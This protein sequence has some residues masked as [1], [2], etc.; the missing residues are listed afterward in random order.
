MIITAFEAL[1][2]ALAL[3]PSSSFT[4]F[5][6]SVALAWGGE[7]E[8]AIEWAE[9]ALRVSPVDRLNYLAYHG[10]A[11]GHFLRG[12]YEEATNAARRGVQS[13]PGFSV[14]RSLLAAPL[15]KL[16]RMEEASAVAK[17]VLE[18]E[19]SFSADGFC[20]ALAVPAALAKPLVEAWREAGLPP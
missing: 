10:L 17:C 11:V 6:G 14:S 8:R 18:L 15:A 4:L 9:R 2:Q 1:E 12:R 20:S 5:F 3:S 19:P 13:N 16:G 7:A